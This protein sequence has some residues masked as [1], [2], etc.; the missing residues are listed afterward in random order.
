MAI[1]ELGPHSG[2]WVVSR[3][4][5]GA[6]V[7]EFFERKNVEKFNPEKVI[8]ENAYQYLCRINEEIKKGK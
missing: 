4:D 8:I 1:P 3:K 6:V 7:G 2:S 5:T